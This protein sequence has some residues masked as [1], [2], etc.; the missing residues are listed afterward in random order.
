[1]VLKK[2]VRVSLLAATMALVTTSIEFESQAQSGAALTPSALRT[3]AVLFSPLPNSSLLT[4]ELVQHVERMATPD[5]WKVPTESPLWNI[6]EGEPVVTTRHLDE[7][8]HTVKYPSKFTLLG[9][10]LGPLKHLQELNPDVDF[11]NLTPGQRV[12]VWKRDEGAVSRSVGHA[13]GGRLYHGEPLPPGDGYKILHPHRTFG[14]YYTVSEIVRV[15]DAYKVRFP[16]ADPLLVGD[17]SVKHG[18]KLAPH[19]SHQSGRD[20]DITYP[21]FD[22]PPSLDRFHTIRRKSFDVE[23]SFWVLKQF[24]DGGNV[25]YMFVDRRW[26]R[27]LREYAEAQG[28][29]EEWLNAVFEYK[30]TRPGAAIIRHERGHA[31]HFHVRFKCQE[32]DAR[33]Q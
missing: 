12:L 13:N 19:R 3:A 21:R 33:C 28:A 32:T 20:V 6:R 23:K 14:T 9:Q 16:Q 11:D 5:R 24:I 22:D 7:L 17:I 31:R 18:R 1:M 26:Q 10:G 29:T 30:S 4:P 8:W 27:P 25:E 2:L 15:L